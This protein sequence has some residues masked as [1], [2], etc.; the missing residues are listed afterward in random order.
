MSLESLQFVAFSTTTSQNE[1]AQAELALYR[2]YQI[3]E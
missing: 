2:S 1:P 3:R